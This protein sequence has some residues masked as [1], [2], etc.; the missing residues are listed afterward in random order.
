MNGKKMWVF[1]QRATNQQQQQN[2]AACLNI[3]NT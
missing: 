1:M 2:T 3:G